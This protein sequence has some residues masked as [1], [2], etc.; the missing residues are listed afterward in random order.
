MEGEHCR[1]WV[2]KSLACSRTRRCPPWSRTV[3]EE[4]GKD[5]VRQGLLSA[6]RAS[7]YS[8]MGQGGTVGP[9]PQKKHGPLPV[10]DSQAERVWGLSPPDQPPLEQGAW[11][12]PVG[13]R[14]T[15]ALGEVGRGYWECPAGKSRQANPSRVAASLGYPAEQGEHRPRASTT[16]PRT[17]PEAASGGRKSGLREGPGLSSHLAW[18]PGCTPSG[19]AWDLSEPGFPE[20]I[21]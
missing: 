10:Q 1:L 7:L 3:V 20:V 2:A 6:D 14:G 21:K 16:K 8:V 17:L 5:T 19:E 18:R 13:W 15:S 9:R 4:V 11:Q 12:W